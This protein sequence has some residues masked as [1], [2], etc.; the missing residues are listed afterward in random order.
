M[1][2]APLAGEGWGGLVQEHALTRSVRDSAALL[3]AV[4]APTPGEPYGVPAKA[5]P[6][7]EEVGRDPGKLRIAFCTDALF[8]DEC[9]RE[10][11]VAVEATARLLESL[12]H[13][14]VEAK[15]AF[16]R[17]DMV[18]AYFLT[19]ATSVA[20][21]VEHTSMAAGC[22]PS[23]RD[24]EPA[25]WLLA[26]MARKSSAPELLAARETIQRVSREVAAFFETHDLLLTSTLARPPA[27]VGELAMQPAERWQIALLNAMPLRSLLR[28]AL[29][30][31]GG[32][33]LAWTPNTQLF[34]QTGQPAVSV[35]L[36]WSQSG[37][38]IGVQFAAR[39][40]DEATL[41]RIA[42]QLEA[43]RPWDQKLPDLVRAT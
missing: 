21:L 13:D 1:T 24:F 37:L 6:W 30:K 17:E 38:P 28:L 29:D 15:P 35:P 32:S 20:S 33:K 3:D 18:R 23:S 40:G 31:M 16:P 7:A 34:N 39:F 41:F 4:D 22:R 11:V 5:R 27:K 8:A 42:S 10:C 14:V 36:A 19:V 12:G 43:A 9:D 26:L 25:T 2:T